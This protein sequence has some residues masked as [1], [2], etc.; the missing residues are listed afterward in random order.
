[1][2][3]RSATKRSIPKILFDAVRRE[4]KPVLSPYQLP[5]SSLGFAPNDAFGP[6]ETKAV[7]VSTVATFHNSIGDIS[8]GQ[9]TQNYLSAVGISF[10]DSSQETIVIGGGEIIGFGS[11]GWGPIKGKFL[12]GGNHI[13]NTIGYDIGSGSAEDLKVL[14][15]YRYVSVRDELIA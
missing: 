2:S 1:M 5:V 3:L 11:H 13:L 4:F 10:W 8:T 6:Q 15:D 14:K 12:P 9:V 7:P